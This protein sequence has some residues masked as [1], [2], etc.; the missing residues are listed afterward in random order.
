LLITY[1][2]WGELFVYTN[3][4]GRKEIEQTSLTILTYGKSHIYPKGSCI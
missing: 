1:Q 3:T 2:Q 4:F